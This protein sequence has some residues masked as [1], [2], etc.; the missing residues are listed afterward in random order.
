MYNIYVYVYIYIYI[1]SFPDWLA[2]L[3]L[4][5]QRR[6]SR[7]DPSSCPS[8]SP[9]HLLPVPLP[10][11]SPLRFVDSKF[12]GNSLWAWE[13]HPLRLRFCLSQTL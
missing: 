11:V 2:A 4:T 1:Y 13:F 7:T 12:P 10:G 8:P 3:R 9:T 5:T 6:T